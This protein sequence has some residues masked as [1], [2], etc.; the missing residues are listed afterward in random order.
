MGFCKQ[1]VVDCRRIDLR[2]H[3]TQALEVQGKTSP[4][5]KHTLITYVK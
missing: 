1:I 5:H 2:L 4:L 3:R